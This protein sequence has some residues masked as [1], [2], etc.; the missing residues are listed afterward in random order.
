MLGDQPQN[1]STASY[2]D[3]VTVGPEAKHAPQSLIA[4]AESQT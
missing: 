1:R 2:L 4:I 3:V